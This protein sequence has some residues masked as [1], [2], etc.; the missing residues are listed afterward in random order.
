MISTRFRLHA[1]LLASGAL[2]LT[3][4]VPVHAQYREKIANDLSKCRADGGP[5]VLVTVDGVKGSRGR[6]RVQSYRA[7]SSDWLAKGRWLA[8][9]EA[10]AKAG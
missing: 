8:R 3:A 6:I 2:A 4:A 9:V 10:P 1:V 7:T 5:A